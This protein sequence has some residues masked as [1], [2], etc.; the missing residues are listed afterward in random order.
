MQK[1]LVPVFVSHVA[2]LS[3]FDSFVFCVPVNTLFELLVLSSLQQGFFMVQFPD[4]DLLS[5]GAILLIG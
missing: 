5:Q 2:S 3:Q 1:Q 4:T